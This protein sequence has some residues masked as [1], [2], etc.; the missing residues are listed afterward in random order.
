MTLLKAILVGGA[1]A[2]ALDMSYAIAAYALRGVPAVSLLQSIASGLY[3]RAAY[4]G[5]LAMAGIGLALHFAMTAVM[6]AGFV[7]L[8][9]IFPVLLR[10]PVLAGVIYGLGLFAIMN[11]I[12]VPL[13]AAYPGTQPQGWL[14]AGALFAHTAL[15]GVPI[16]LAARHY[17]LAG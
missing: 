12:V 1:A 2:G 16:A 3:G 17:L 10:A 9:L 15:V 11:F 4:D 13:S 7:I 6:A 14:L 5:G 8:A